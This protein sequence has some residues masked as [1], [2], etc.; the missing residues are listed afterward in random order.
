MEVAIRAAIVSVRYHRKAFE[1]SPNKPVELVE[2]SKTFIPC[3]ILILLMPLLRH[4]HG[5]EI[6]VAD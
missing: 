6:L 5:I 4:L 3:T 2:Q 1:L